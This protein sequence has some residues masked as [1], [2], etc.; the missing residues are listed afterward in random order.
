MK[1][2]SEQKEKKKKLPLGRTLQN[3]LFALRSIFEASPIYLL[4]YLG[5]SFVYGIVDF[6]SEGFMLR[7]IVDGIDSGKSIESIAQPP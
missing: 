2:E 5:S 1:K 7:M 6:L 4:V 3:N